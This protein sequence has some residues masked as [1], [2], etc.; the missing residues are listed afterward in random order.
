M[1]DET[2]GQETGKPRKRTT[3]KTPTRQAVN[4]V[5]CTLHL[6]IEASRKLDIHA[7]M[8]SCDRSALIDKL[9]HEH[10]RRW[11]VSDRGG[12]DPHGDSG[13]AAA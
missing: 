2:A 5:K 4:K 1:G 8:M 12:G 13:E 6:S 7:T 11:V 10:L 3:A 9:I